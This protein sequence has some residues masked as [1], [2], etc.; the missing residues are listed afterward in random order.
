[1]GTITLSLTQTLE[2]K[3]EI[4]RDKCYPTYT[5]SDAVKE[6]FKDSLNAKVTDAEV[7]QQ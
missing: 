1:M 6:F 7:D 5:V 3:A 4:L 2:K